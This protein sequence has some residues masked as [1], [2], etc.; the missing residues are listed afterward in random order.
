MV[1]IFSLVRVGSFNEAHLMFQINHVYLI[2][3]KLDQNSKTPTGEICRN[4]LGSTCKTKRLLREQDVW[5]HWTLLTKL[6]DSQGS[7]MHEYIKISLP[8]DP[9]LFILR[10]TKD[11]PLLRTSPTH[12]YLAQDTNMILRPL[13][14]QAY[15]S[16]RWG[17]PLKPYPC[18]S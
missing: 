9:Q 14:F 13:P 5:T 8:K 6:K 4:P 11:R 2:K 1:E 7:K 17:L 10:C 15:D 18:P 16:P 12:L 3:Y